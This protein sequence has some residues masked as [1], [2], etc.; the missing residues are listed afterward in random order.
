M[1]KQEAKTNQKETS[2]QTTKATVL[3]RREMHKNN[4][5]NAN[6]GE[7]KNTLIMERSHS[8]FEKSSSS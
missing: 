4:Q 5:I 2:E 1:R 6:I 8:Q 3:S 7:F